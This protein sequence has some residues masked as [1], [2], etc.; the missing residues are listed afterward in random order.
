[1]IEEIE[2]WRLELRKYWNIWIVYS[3]VRI[4]NDEV[5]TSNYLFCDIKP[6]KVWNMLNCLE[7]LIK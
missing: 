2:L 6:G 7:S 1:M 4:I 5:L 3:A